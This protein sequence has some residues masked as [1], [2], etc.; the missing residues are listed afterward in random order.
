MSAKIVLKIL[1][2][3]NVVQAEGDMASQ[4]KTEKRDERP[5]SAGEEPWWPHP[6]KTETE[7]WWPHPLKTETESWWPHPLKTETECW[8]PHQLK[9]ETECW[10]PHPLKT[11][12]EPCGAYLLEPEIVELC[13][14][15]S[16]SV[17]PE[18]AGEANNSRLKKM[19]AAETPRACDPG[20]MKTKSAPAKTAKR[21]Q[22]AR[23]VFSHNTTRKNPGICSKYTQ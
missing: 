7:P 23:R 9:A 13:P 22:N 5:E 14:L 10:R 6:L 21:R 17:C 1:M 12:T 16:K 4:V 3:T 15:K 19:A 20:T 18:S 11:E 2:Q 8:W